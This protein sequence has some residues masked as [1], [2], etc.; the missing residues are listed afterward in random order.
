LGRIL[1]IVQAHLLTQFAMNALPTCLAMQVVR[2]VAEA[3]PAVT[4]TKVAAAAKA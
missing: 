2:I 1:W 4:D 3:A